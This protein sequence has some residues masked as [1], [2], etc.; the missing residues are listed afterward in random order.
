ME[1]TPESR[2]E[3][4]SRSRAAPRSRR[5]ASSEG[6]VAARRTTSLAAA[7]PWTEP[8]A[9]RAAGVNPVDS[10]ASGD[11]TRLTR[12]SSRARGASTESPV[13]SSSSAAPIGTRGP[14]R[15]PA[16]YGNHRG[17]DYQ[18]RRTACEQSRCAAVRASS[19]SASVSC[20]TYRLSMSTRMFHAAQGVVGGRE[21]G[22]FDSPEELCQEPDVLA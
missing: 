3:S 9:I 22:A 18:Q 4:G 5:A 11:T 19:R 13:S 8:S 14:R 7:S 6:A 17:S 10:T 2:R 20:M 21:R 1:G 16:L 12:P 15:A